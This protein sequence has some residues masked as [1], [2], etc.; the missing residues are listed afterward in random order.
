MIKIQNI[1]RVICL[2]LALV[3]LILSSCSGG[4]NKKEGI[5]ILCTIYP[6]Y[7]WVKSIVGEA[8]G[9]TVSLLVENGADVHSYQPSVDDIV[10]IKKSDA[11]ILVGGESDAWIYEA[12]EGAEG[13]AITLFELEDMILYGVSDEYIA[14]EHDHE[15][16]HHHEDVIDEHV[17]LSVANARTS[18]R[19]ICEWLCENDPDNA[20]LYRANTDEYIM[21]LD[22]LDE[23]FKTLSD[24]ADTPV[25]FADRFPFVYLFEEYGISYYAAFEGCST[26]AEADFGTVARLAERL[27]EN[28]G[29][30]IAVSE[31]SDERIAQSVMSAAKLECKIARF[32][33]M[34]SVTAKDIAD[35]YS[36]IG[37]M[38]KNFEALE[39]ILD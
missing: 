3:T 34:Q 15:H 11:V 30:Y 9:V 23:S 26:D 13:E 31:S 32:D 4:G 24:K 29:G 5:E 10:R 18:C 38:Q 12:L 22:E 27:K 2:L 35:G 1:K 6:Q 8:Q 17:W 36:Y 7:D 19:A 39:M 25:I 16:S 28:G 20:M 33:S 14:S 37:A 21:K